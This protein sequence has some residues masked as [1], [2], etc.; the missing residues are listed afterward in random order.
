MIESL[1]GGNDRLDG[2]SGNDIL[3]GDAGQPGRSLG[4]DDRLDGGSGD[5]IL[6]GDASQMI[7]GSE[8]PPG[9]GTTS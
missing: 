3:Y 1:R 8:T 5:D 7:G 6:Y 9:A 4:G 2:G